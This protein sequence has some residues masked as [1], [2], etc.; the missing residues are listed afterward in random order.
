MVGRPGAGREVV[1]KPL[2]L[3]IG[4]VVGVTGGPST[5]ATGLVGALAALRDESLECTVLTDTPEVF[6]ALPGVR[7]VR[8]PLPSSWVQPWWDNVAIPWQLRAGF[9]VYHGTKHALPLLG[10]PSSTRQ[11][12]TIHDLA[13]YAEPETFSWAQR[14]QVRVHSRHAAQRA[15]R[16]ICDSRHAAE[17]VERRLG[18]ARER[19]AV[20][21]LGVAASFAPSSDLA[22]RREVRERLGV[23]EQGFLLAYAGTAQPRKR[24]EVAI[25]ATQRLRARGLEVVFAIAGRRRPG[26]A[27]DWMRRPPA[28]VRLLGELPEAELVALLGAADCML[29]PSS[30]EGFGLTFAEAMACGTPVVG[31]ATTSIPEVVGEGGLLVEA[32]G[33]E[34]IADALTRL[35]REP[36]LRAAKSRAALEEARRFSWQRTAEQTL[37]VYRGVAAS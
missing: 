24:I 8:V 10:T 33:E 29:S 32:S 21:P 20:I 35:L 16:I 30:Y 31:V 9:D 2:R 17:D 36:D 23:R 12:V 22:A 6:A 25:A 26:Y 13:A 15:A 1:V 18:V 28:H 11:V 14:L 5:Y 19:I 27:P 4:A 3:A 37:E 34:A 7:T